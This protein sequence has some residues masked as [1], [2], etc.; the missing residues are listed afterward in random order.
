MSTSKKSENDKDKV[1]IIEAWSDN[2]LVAALFIFLVLLGFI[3][4]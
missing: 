4:R 2:L 3:V 1:S